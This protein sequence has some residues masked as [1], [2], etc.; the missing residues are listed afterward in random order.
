MRLDSIT[1][2]L[3]FITFFAEQTLAADKSEFIE[4][5]IEFN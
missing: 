3:V 5:F 2:L 4:V 1:L